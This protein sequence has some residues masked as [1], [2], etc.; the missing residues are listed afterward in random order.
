MA[1]TAAQLIYVLPR[2]L[3]AQAVED[4]IATCLHQLAAKAGLTDRKNY[5]ISV[6]TVTSPVQKDD[7]CRITLA[8]ADFSAWDKVS[9]YPVYMQAFKSVAEAYDLILISQIQSMPAHVEVFA[10]P[11]AKEYFT[12]NYGLGIQNR[13][14]TTFFDA[15]KDTVVTDQPTILDI[16]LSVPTIVNKIKTELGIKNPLCELID[17]KVDTTTDEVTY[18]V[19]VKGLQKQSTYTAINANWRHWPTKGLVELV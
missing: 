8:F 12:L 14:P 18:T 19:L 15:A 16:D 4:V 2:W 5:T 11:D 6:K 3:Q 1:T 9:L 7:E 13:V 10:S 17:V